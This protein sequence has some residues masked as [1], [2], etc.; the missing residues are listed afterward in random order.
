MPEKLND[1]YV[2]YNGQDTTEFTEVIGEEI[3]ER[4]GEDCVVRLHIEVYEY[5]E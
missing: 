5:P 1:F 2:I 3:R 4:Y